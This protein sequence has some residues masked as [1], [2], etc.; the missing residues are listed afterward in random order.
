VNRE[1]VGVYGGTFDPI[2]VAHIVAAVEARAALRLDRLLMVVAGDPW[3]K[4]GRVSAAAEDRFAM[5]EAVAA[6]LDGIEASRLEL[7]R[8]GPAYTAETL[9]V[10]SSPDR[11]LFLIVGSDLVTAL[12]TWNDWERIA[13]LCTLAVVGRGGDTLTVPGPPWKAEQITIPRLDISSS[14]IRDRALHG[15]PIEGLVPA[16]ALRLLRARGLYTARQ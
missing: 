9:E 8:P 15:R 14:D 7:D 1:R 10:L 5:V 12:P 3:Q 16:A 6:E 11:D 2:H 4:R 13:G